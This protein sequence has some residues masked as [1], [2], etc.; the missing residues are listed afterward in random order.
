MR[1]SE[2]N[3]YT[4]KFTEIQCDVQWYS[5]EQ[6]YAAR[7]TLKYTV[8]CQDTLCY[9]EI[10]QHTPRNIKICFFTLWGIWL[11]W[12]IYF[13]DNSNYNIAERLDT[14]F[15][16]IHPIPPSSFNFVWISKD[17]TDNTGQH[18]TWQDRTGHDRTR[19][20]RTRQGKTCRKNTIL[21]WHQSQSC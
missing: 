20:N 19:Q 17:K 8:V 7:D 15:S 3:W 10:H 21:F 16:R 14:V 6:Q 2:I 1:Y 9:T 18:S 4:P 11:A 12:V 13:L 5:K